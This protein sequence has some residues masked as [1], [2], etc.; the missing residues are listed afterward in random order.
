MRRS[1]VDIM[2]S[3]GSNTTPLVSIICL[4]YNQERYIR[5]AIEGFLIQKTAFPFEIIIHD[6]ASTDQTTQIILSYARD[7]PVLIKPIIQT[8]NQYSLSPNQIVKIP[9]LCAK[10]LFL[11]F[12]EGDDYWI[13]P[14]KLEKQFM[15]MQKYSNCELS[16]HSARAEYRDGSSAVISRSVEQIKVFSAR[17]VIWGGGGFCPTASLM[18]KRGV[19]D[20]LFS[21]IDE[22]NYLYDY[23]IQIFASLKGG[24]LYINDVMSVYRVGS[25]GSWSE[26]TRESFSFYVLQM[27]KVIDALAWINRYSK[28]KYSVV[29]RYMQ[30]KAYVTIFYK[31]IIRYFK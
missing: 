17:R 20:V 29:I 28:G 3:W 13:D 12:C 1:E 24:A 27:Y 16:F 26:K 15:A 2:K 21:V 25:V 5:S 23:V 22:Q 10:G 31:R 4:A 30:I 7:Y 19:F 9:I 6:D 11:A 14:E 18:I 8:Q